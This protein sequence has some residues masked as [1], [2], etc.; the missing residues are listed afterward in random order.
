MSENLDKAAVVEPAVKEVYEGKREKTYQILYL[1]D[2]VVLLRCEDVHGNRENSHRLERRDHFDDQLESGFFT[3][4]PDSDVD[5]I[6][7]ENEDWYEVTH[8]GQKTAE[9]LE[10]AGYKTALDVRSADDEELR[11]ITGLGAAGLENLR[12]FTR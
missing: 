1:D 9:R 6:D 2:Q 8:V 3:H 12:A 5:L 7:F 10:E 11:N 4:K